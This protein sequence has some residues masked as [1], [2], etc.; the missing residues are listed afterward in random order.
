MKLLV[1]CQYFYPEPFRVSDVCFQLADMGHEV[2]VITGI[3]NYPEGEIYPEY[4]E[5]PPFLETIQ[6]VKVYRG[7]LR[8]RKKGNKNLARNYLSFIFQ[9]SRRVFSAYKEIGRVDHILV[10]QYSP[11]TMAVPALLYQTIAGKRNG[12]RIPLS[13]YCFDLWPESIVSAGL[14]GKGLL[15]NMVRHMSR[16]IYSQA[17]Q[18]Q[19]SSKQFQEYFQSK[20]GLNGPFHHLPIYAE[21]LFLKSSN[22]DESKKIKETESDGVTHLLFAGNIGEMQSID[23]II[24]AASLLKAQTPT[25]KD[26]AITGRLEIHFVGDG[27]ALPQGME[28]AQSEG[29]DQSTN[30]AVFFHG[31]H[32]VT[33]MPKFYDLAD[34]F[35]VT[36][37][38]DPF[39]SYTLPGKVQ[40]YMAAGKPII[41]AINGETAQVIEESGCGIC[42]PAEDAEVLAS[43]IFN[44]IKMDKNTRLELGQSG[45]QYYFMNF[46]RESFF[47]KLLPLI[48]PKQ[49][50]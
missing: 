8:P 6:G 9:G 23:T 10:F 16:W 1:V 46:S 42:G 36:L 39:I 22:S 26:S 11:V 4:R 3:P 12:K 45:L 18:I 41:G 27:S 17:D 47:S 25:G 5:N 31:R 33:D 21:E 13:I 34:A 19:I 30:P 50:Y 24:K 15:Y 48:S 49:P 2:T 35:L 28:L 43:N 40:S 38:A 44:F 20:L 14:K 7:N 29:L 32:P 37:K